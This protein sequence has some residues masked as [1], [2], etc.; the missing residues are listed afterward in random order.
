MLPCISQP[1]LQSFGAM[2]LIWTS[3]FLHRVGFLQV[4]LCESGLSHLEAGHLP[5]LPCAMPWRFWSPCVPY[6]IASDWG[7]ATCF[8]SLGCTMAMN[9]YLSLW[10]FGFSIVAPTINYPDKQICFNHSLL[11]GIETLDLWKYRLKSKLCHIL[12]YFLRPVIW[13]IWA[14]ICSS[15]RWGDNADYLKRLL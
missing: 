2:W 13:F 12:W 9:F 5:Y 7:K 10:N 1:P 8:T 6:G 4:F 15:V 14:S 3:R 11:E